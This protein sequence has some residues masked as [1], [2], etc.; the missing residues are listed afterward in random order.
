MERRVSREG[1]LSSSPGA[2]PNLKT[3][4]WH[5]L[6]LLSNPVAL[7][8]V[9]DKIGK[10]I[11]DKFR[12][13]RVFLVDA[14]IWMGCASRYSHPHPQYWKS[15]KTIPGWKGEYLLGNVGAVH[16]DESTYPNSHA[17]VY[18]QFAYCEGEFKMNGKPWSPFAARR[19]SGCSLL[20]TRAVDPI[21][22]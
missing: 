12:D 22:I 17:F 7:A 10:A 13:S 16:M 1:S 21:L 3:I 2:C 5:F 8:A 4:F 20:S 9:R 19:H 15:D 14:N 6:I 18:D 11:K